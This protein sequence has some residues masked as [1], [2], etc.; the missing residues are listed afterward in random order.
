MKR[1]LSFAT[2]DGKHFP[3]CIA[4]KEVVCCLFPQRGNRYKRRSEYFIQ[5]SEIWNYPSDF[6][7]NKCNILTKFIFFFSKI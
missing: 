5:S 7:K 6:I 3:V 2:T 4:F 1:I